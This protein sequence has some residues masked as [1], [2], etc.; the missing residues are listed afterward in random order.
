MASFFTYWEGPI[1]KYELLCF[2]SHIQS[3]HSL[4]VFSNEN[5]SLPKEI[6]QYP[7]NSVLKT[8]LLSLL[9][10]AQKADLFRFQ[11]LKQFGGEIWVDGDVLCAKEGSFQ[12]EYIFAKEFETYVIGSLKFPRNHPLLDYVIAQQENALRAK[13]SL[14]WSALGPKI[15]DK[16][17]REFQL[18][19]R[20]LETSQL[21]PLTFRDIDLLIDPGKYEDVQRKITNSRSIH[22][23]GEMF[24]RSKYPKHLFPPKGSFLFEQ[25]KNLGFRVTS[26]NTMDK[27]SFLAWKVRYLKTIQFITL[28]SFTKYLKFIN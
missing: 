12:E 8:N 21:Y 15:F 23:Y 25:F 4:K 24:R 10:P 22:L 27:K 5:L 26:E 14:Y 28:K 13:T 7:V 1:T 19:N 9:S 20:A 3:G 16:A 11:G 2:L 18:E 17:I 6:Q